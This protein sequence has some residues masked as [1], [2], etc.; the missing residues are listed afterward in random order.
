VTSSGAAIVLDV[1]VTTDIH[2]TGGNI[3][4]RSHLLKA[5][6]P[7]RA[8]GRRGGRHGGSN[9]STNTNTNSSTG[10]KTRSQSHG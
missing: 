7:A 2:P 5:L 1:G 6:K 10:S 3:M 4:A 9:G 8:T